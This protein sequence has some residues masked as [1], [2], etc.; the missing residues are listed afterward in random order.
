MRD[1]EAKMARVK[2]RIIEL[3]AAAAKDT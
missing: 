1:T 3:E 2:L